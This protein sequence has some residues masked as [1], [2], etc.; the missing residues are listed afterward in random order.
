MNRR[1]AILETTPPQSVSKNIT[2][3]FV[4]IR[5]VMADFTFSCKLELS[6]PFRTFFAQDY[7][8]HDSTGFP[9]R[10]RYSRPTV[11]GGGVDPVIPWWLVRSNG[12]F[13][14]IRRSRF[15][16]GFN[17]QSKRSFKRAGKVVGRSRWKR[18][19]AEC[20]GHACHAFEF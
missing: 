2:C 20:R 5:G 9:T 1:Y 17:R 10:L 4:R 12:R 11:L 3:T 7:K 6:V 8:Q 13:A 19:A 14:D 15:V 18:C 16:A